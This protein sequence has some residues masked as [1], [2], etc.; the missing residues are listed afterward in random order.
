MKRKG[1]NLTKISIRLEKNAWTGAWR[2]SQLNEKSDWWYSALAVSSYRNIS[3]EYTFEYFRKI[4][5]ISSKWKTWFIAI[6][7]SYIWTN[8]LANVQY[9][10][11]NTFQKRIQ[12]PAKHL[13]WS[14][15]LKQLTAESHSLFLKKV[16]IL[17]V[18]QAS[19]SPLAVLNQYLIEQA[20][21][22]NKYQLNQK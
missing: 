3:F 19:E 10:I 16:S 7:T 6:V 22:S 15:L 4:R 18:W 13:R 1:W 5:N 8:I 17:D 14:S 9:S 20:L 12:N 21:L 2:N 11:D